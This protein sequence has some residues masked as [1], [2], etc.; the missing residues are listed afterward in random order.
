LGCRCCRRRRGGGWLTSS[1]LTI[2]CTRWGLGGRG[3][4]PSEGTA[5]GP[6]A[7]A[8]AVRQALLF[9]HPLLLLSR[10]LPLWNC[11]GLLLLSLLLLHRCCSRHRCSCARLRA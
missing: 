10:R 11:P 4:P 1:C 9:L 2:S 6:W 7:A 5:P 3:V 8:A